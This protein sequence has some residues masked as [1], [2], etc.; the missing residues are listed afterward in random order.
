MKSIDFQKSQFRIEFFKEFTTFDMLVGEVKE[1]PGRRFNAPASGEKYW[2]A[3]Q[4]SF[5]QVR[6]YGIKH[7]FQFTYAAEQAFST[8]TAHKEAEVPVRPPSFEKLPLKPYDH[9]KSGVVWLTQRRR[10]IL[11]DE[12]GLGKTACALLAA[13]CFEGADIHVICPASLQ[14]NWRREARMWNVELTGIHSWAK[15]PSTLKS[16]FVLIV[17][18]AHYAQAGNG[19]QRGRAFLA[20]SEWAEAVFMLTG[21]PLKNGRPI[22]LLPLLQASRHQLAANVRSYHIR[23]CNAKKTHWSRW[24]VSGARNLDE[25]HEQTRDVILR[26]RKSECLDLPPKT[27]VTREVDSTKES[28]ERYQRALRELRQKY[29]ERLA[30]GIITTGGEALVMMG[31]L[32]LASSVAKVDTAIELA[33]EI[34]EQQGAV[35]IFT[36]FVESGKAIAE[37]LGTELFCGEMAQVHRQQLIDG[38]QKNGGAFVGTIGAGGVGITL[39]KAST[40]LMV[41]RP[42]TPGDAVQA[43][44]RLHR[45]GQENKVVSMWLQYDDVDKSIDA[46]LEQKEGRIELI[47]QGK[48]KTLRGQSTAEAVAKEVLERV[49]SDRQE[50]SIFAE[51]V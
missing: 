18:E 38:F 14:E 27:R 11:A 36:Q 5:E 9:Q 6:D 10:A 33:Q 42:W 13:D 35:V 1:I 17:D 39:T 25:L 46:L 45:I 24:D 30:K 50:E 26:R 12:M 32:R 41:D 8:L 20:L 19:S 49:I 3:P 34:I 21:T 51:A 47:L 15:V 29:E 48:R 4:T 22:N 37:E 23:Y 43:E 44:D 7:H 16:P 28:D 40:V 31:H 2:T